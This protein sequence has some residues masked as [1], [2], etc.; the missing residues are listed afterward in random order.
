MTDRTFDRLVSFDPKSKRFGIAALVEAKPVRGKTWY[1]PGAPYKTRQNTDQG[2]EG[3]CPGFGWTNELIATPKAWKFKTH[4]QA[5]KFAREKIYWEAQ[6]VDEWPGGAYPGAAP[7]YE[8]SSVLA[9]AK[10]VQSLGYMDEYRWAFNVDEAMLAVAHEGPV[11]VGTVWTDDMEPRPSGLLEGTSGNER[12]GHCYL[13]RGVI[14]K[15][16]LR[17]EKLTEPVFLIT[18]SWGDGW[19]KG[20][21][22][23]IRV[24]DFEKL[25]A[26]Q[27]EVCVPVRRR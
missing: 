22:A 10:V 7:Q 11:V 3:A 26:K 5:N 23:Y 16:K 1:Y 18:N 19:G 4:E 8:G 24:A 6:K 9:A 13:I 15:P 2:Q 12:G 17:G 27:G 21:D 20:G 14:L 25:M